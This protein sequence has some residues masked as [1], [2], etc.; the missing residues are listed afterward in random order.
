MEVRAK[1]QEAKKV[2]C[3]LVRLDSTNSLLWAPEWC[4][5]QSSQPRLS[6]KGYTYPFKL[7]LNHRICINFWKY[8]K[9]SIC[10][11]VKDTKFKQCKLFN[12]LNEIHVRYFIS[13][14]IL[15]VA[16]NKTSLNKSSLTKQ[17]HPFL[18]AV[19]Y[20]NTLKSYFFELGTHLLVPFAS[21]S[22][23]YPLKGKGSSVSSQLQGQV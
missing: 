9:I 7:L 2:S 17:E 15:E 12:I 13:G 20:T 19:S 6:E 8:G 5:S 22:R 14:Q 18:L 4:P 16:A 10:S 1:H 21:L 23:H 11:F 3:D